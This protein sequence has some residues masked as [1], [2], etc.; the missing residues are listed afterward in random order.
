MQ[1]SMLFSNEVCKHVFSR[2]GKMVTSLKNPQTD[3]ISKNLRNNTVAAAQ[4]LRCS[5][6]GHFYT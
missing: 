6:G 4:Y 5:V 3:I 2:S 1:L